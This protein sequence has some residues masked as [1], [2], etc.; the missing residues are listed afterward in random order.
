MF[1]TLIVLNSKSNIGRLTRANDFGMN[2]KVVG[3]VHKRVLFTK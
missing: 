1:M 2:I 3:V